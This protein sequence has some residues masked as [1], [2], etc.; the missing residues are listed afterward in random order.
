VALRIET[1]R[2][3]SLD[4]VKVIAV[5]MSCTELSVKVEG[6]FNARF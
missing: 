4:M 2:D 1:D 5:A 6:A 3:G